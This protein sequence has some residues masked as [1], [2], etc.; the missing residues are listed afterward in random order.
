MQILTVNSIRLPV[1]ASAEE[2]FS[3]AR[4][5]FKKAGI[6]VS[7]ECLKIS[8]RSVDARKKDDISFVYSVSVSGD[9]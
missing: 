9:F 1:N 7:R 5:K 6:N 8:R 3:V 2:A 4:A